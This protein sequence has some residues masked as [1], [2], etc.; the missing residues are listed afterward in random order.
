MSNTVFL[1]SNQLWH[2][3][4]TVLLTTVLLVLY[5]LLLLPNIVLIKV[6]QIRQDWA[7]YDLGLYRNLSTSYYQEEAAS[8]DETGAGRRE[9][10]NTNLTLHQ[11]GWEV[12][13]VVERGSATH[14][15]VLVWLRF[16]HCALAPILM[17]ALSKELRGKAAA[18]VGCCGAGRATT[19]P[20]P[21]SALLHRQNMEVNRQKQM[22]KA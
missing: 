1:A 16:I 9:E 3:L 11:T 2:E 8:V 19:A 22:N 6:D 4:R 5:L 20:R 7:P 18:L 14:E 17:L 21:I 12:P 13:E 10:G 15:T